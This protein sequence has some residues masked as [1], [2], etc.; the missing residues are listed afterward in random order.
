[1]SHSDFWTP[2]KTEELRQAIE[3]GLSQSRAAARV[4]T[5]PGSVGSKA[6]RMGLEFK[7]DDS[8]QGGVARSRMVVRAQQKRAAAV[9]DEK[10]VAGPSEESATAVRFLDAGFFHC[11]YPLWPGHR[12]PDIRQ[13]MVCGAPTAIKSWC[14]CHAA[15]VF[16]KPSGTVSDK[17]MQSAARAA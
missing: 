8:A 6:R 1:M 13:A 10:V 2:E 11:R 5:T 4:G 15:K 9:D 14:A 12:P 17:S 7:G 3:D 16:A